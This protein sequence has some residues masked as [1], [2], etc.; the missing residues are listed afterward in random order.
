MAR[1]A[2]APA[3]S[4][5]FA[6][7]DFE[8]GVGGTTRQVA[9]QGRSLAAR[10]YD[11]VV[12]TRRR[13][14]DWP[15]REEIAGLE[16]HRLGMPGRSRVREA[17][18]V[19]DL[20]FWLRRRRGR[21]DAF[22]LVMWPD[23][24]LAG[25]LAG[26]L[27]RTATV[28]AISGEAAATVRDAASP[29]RRALVGLRRSLLRRTHHVALTPRMADELRTNEVAT[30]SV[31]IPVPVDAGHFRPPAPE[32]RLEARRAL[33]IEPDSFVVVHVGHL[34]Q[35]KAIDRLVRAFALLE[36][37][38]PKGR[39]LLVGGGRGTAEDTEPAL[40]HLVAE[41]GLDDAV[42]FLGVQADPRPFLWAADALVLISVREGM[43]NSLLEGMACGL[44]C[45]ASE[46]AGG[47]ELLEADTG[48]VTGS[49]DPHE[50]AAAL[51]RLATDGRL[52][53]EL[54]QTARGRVQRYDADVVADAYEQLFEELAGGSA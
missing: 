23:A 22:A 4:V 35:R 44:P 46:S 42:A 6:V 48:I 36:R 11:V 43:P 45:V 17:L 2:T 49:N 14:R 24:Q 12:V 16:V 7:P 31:V 29:G 51:E 15:R 37:A 18:A 40:R 28:W 1:V 27:S 38:A 33:G 39:L 25:Y 30:R 21:F 52:R 41:L 53:A 10:G 54:G 19:V 50:V 3:R 34:E 13:R 32:E 26:V 47:S 9:I 5:V 20:A 8:P